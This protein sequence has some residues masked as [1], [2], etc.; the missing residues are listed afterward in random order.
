LFRQV[1]IKCETGI[2][3]I[4]VERGT[5]RKERREQEEWK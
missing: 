2:L 3:V 4:L 5:G 1:D